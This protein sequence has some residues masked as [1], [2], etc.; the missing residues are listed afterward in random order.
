ML[1]CHSGDVFVARQLMRACW[2]ETTEP[3]WMAVSL[4]QRPIRV[5]ALCL[6]Y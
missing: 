3:V 2:M 1:L 6:E 5:F 4:L